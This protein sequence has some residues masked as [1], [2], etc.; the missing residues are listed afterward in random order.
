MRKYQLFLSLEHSD[1][2]I[3][4]NFVIRISNF[5]NNLIEERYN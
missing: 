1:F 5:S 4:S 3:V 2:D